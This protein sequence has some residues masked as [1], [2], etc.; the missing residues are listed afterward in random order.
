[1]IS[2]YG[3]DEFVLLTLN[4]TVEEN[5]AVA[6]RLAA[7]LSQL[8]WP[9]GDSP[10]QISVTIGIACSTLLPH[11]NVEELLAV[12]DRDLYA[13]KS[14]KKRP[15]EGADVVL[16]TPVITEIKAA[17]P[18]PGASDARQVHPYGWQDSET[19]RWCIGL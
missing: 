12:A 6:E 10:L 4:L 8:R 11:A 17:P 18:T 3:G 2:R 5:A 19:S 1:M 13:R 9:A 16:A 15:P 7:E 14:R